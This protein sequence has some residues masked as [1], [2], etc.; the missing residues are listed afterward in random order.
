MDENAQLDRIINDLI[1]NGYLT[2]DIEDIEWLCDTAAEVFLEEPSLLEIEPPVN[3]CGDIH[4]QFSDLIRVLQCHD[5]DENTKYL[6][7]GDYV[8][9]GEQSLEVVC[10][11]F[12]MKLRFPDNIFLLRGNHE[13]PEMTE[14][15][16]FVDECE[17]KLDYSIVSHFHDLFDCLPI[18]AVVGEKIFCV[19]GGLS[20]SLKS[21][22]DIRSVVR[23]CGIPEEG[24]V[25]DLLW[26]DPSP[27]TETWGPNDRG[28]TFTWG[29]RIAEKFLDDNN[30]ERIVRGHQM[31]FGG[32]D[33]PFAPNEDVIT[34]FTASC[35]ANRFTNS[36][37]FLSVN[38]SL[39]MEFVVL[40]PRAKDLERQARPGTARV[41]V[42]LYEDDGGIEVNQVEVV[43]AQ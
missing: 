21:L 19:H 16:G 29:L 8:D 33:F 18:A 13:S 28:S 4:G 3:I 2:L 22:D 14:S 20:P 25:A 17:R 15:F 24:I 11:L 41:A 23:P 37:A 10:L 30:L 27:A 26:S 38:E 42:D 32:Y 39:E 31:A 36:A 40:E 9:R 12:A 35:Y 6:F 43:D 34:I 7:L 5:F 1:T